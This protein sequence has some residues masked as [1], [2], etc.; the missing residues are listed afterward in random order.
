M[1][2]YGPGMTF[3]NSKNS[4]NMVG[5]AS[6]LN[7]DL[8]AGYI[9]RKIDVLALKGDTFGRPMTYIGGNIMKELIVSVTKHAKA[10]I[11]AGLLLGIAFAAA[12]SGEFDRISEIGVD[13]LRVESS[14]LG[15]VVRGESRL[16]V[17]G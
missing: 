11:V 15:V 14:M 5:L 4:H 12:A 17:E 2:T 10:L 13:E 16:N 1:Q 3:N 7:G 6:E 9:L 8:P